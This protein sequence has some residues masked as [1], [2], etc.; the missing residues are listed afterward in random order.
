MIL[1]VGVKPGGNP[2][3]QRVASLRIEGPGPVALMLIWSSLALKFDDRN[4]LIFVFRLRAW[5]GFLF[6]LPKMVMF[7][8]CFHEEFGLKNDIRVFVGRL[9]KK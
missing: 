9:H 7:F 8:V 1:Q 6:T 5:V 4:D 3:L 2:F